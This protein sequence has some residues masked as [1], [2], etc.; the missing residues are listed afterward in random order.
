MPKLAEIWGLFAWVLGV[1]MFA[2]V[3]SVYRRR[4]L[5]RF[6]TFEIVG[7]ICVS[8]FAG[9]MTFLACIGVGVTQ[10]PPQDFA[11]MALVAFL[12]GIAAHTSAR[13]LTIYDKAAE[14]RMRKL[15]GVEGESGATEK[16]DGDGTT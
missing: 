1:C 16:G 7:E 14:D 11:R 2:G 12:C 10:V 15:L 5:E 9:L 4:K 13:I 8:G 3:I 6:S